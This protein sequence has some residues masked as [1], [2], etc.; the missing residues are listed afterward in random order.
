MRNMFSRLFLVHTFLTILY[1]EN[2]PK[3]VCFTRYWYINTTYSLSL[4]KLYGVW[5]PCINSLKLKMGLTFGFL[6]I[7]LI[8]N[9]DKPWQAQRKYIC[10]K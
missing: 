10:T 4:P 3:N 8:L 9:D 5:S 2:T 1:K 7:I 6:G